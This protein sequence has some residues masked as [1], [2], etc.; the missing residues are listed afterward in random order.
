[1]KN[2]P[3]EETQ[4]IDTPTF[5]VSLSADED[6]GELCTTPLLTK[7]RYLTTLEYFQDTTLPSI[8]KAFDKLI[9][10]HPKYKTAITKAMPF[11]IILEL[12]SDI[13]CS[14]SGTTEIE[15]THLATSKN[16]R[17]MFLGI[18]KATAPF[19]SLD[20]TSMHEV[21]HFISSLFISRTS[22]EGVPLEESIADAFTIWANKSAANYGEWRQEMI[23]IWQ[24]DLLNN[25]SNSLTWV[26]AFHAL[27]SSSKPY[28]RNFKKEFHLSRFYSY[29]QS[30]FA[31]SIINNLFFQLVS[32]QDY[33]QLLE[34]FLYLL[35]EKPTLFTSNRLDL[36]T[37]EL[38]S[39]DWETLERLGWQDSFEQI[40]ATQT[41]KKIK[42]EDREV[43]TF[44]QSTLSMN[45]NK[46]D[47][48]YGIRI[49][50][51]DILL[52]GI[53]FYATT[54][55]SFNENQI[56]LRDVSQCLNEYADLPCICTNKDDILSIKYYFNKVDTGYFET[57]DI[58]VP[59]DLKEGC[60]EV[61]TYFDPF[62]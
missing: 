36:I 30:H 23:D 20:E 41:F 29:S 39:I 19:T 53:S 57:N 47:N 2:W 15:Q 27:E 45:Y 46:V 8:Q 6:L 26:N 54:S 25:P 1:L 40:D 18:G 21:G 5:T 59:I 24:L 31:S 17:E 52:N 32:P 16:K 50:P 9:K 13:S 38:S 49:I 28:M 10:I 58:K 34:K 14:G 22:A 4:Y 11:N 3:I 44:E 7:E 35:A 37:N 61:D 51:Y 43:V 56:V 62:N 33:H 48:P 12:R 55:Y 42:L 60:Y